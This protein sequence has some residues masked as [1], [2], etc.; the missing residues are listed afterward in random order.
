MNEEHEEIEEIVEVEET[1][2]LLTD[3]IEEVEASVPRVFKVDEPFNFV[4]IDLSFAPYEIHKEKGKKPAKKY[5]LNTVP[6]IYAFRNA[7]LQLDKYCKAEKIKSG[8]TIRFVN[9]HI[10]KGKT[11]MD[12]IYDFGKAV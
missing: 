12:T 1:E 10:P 8:E 6:P 9:R 7:Y 2:E 3:T 5:T 11:S 4:I